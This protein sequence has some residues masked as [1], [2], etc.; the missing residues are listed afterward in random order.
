MPAAENREKSFA[1]VVGKE[2]G[3]ITGAYR[4]SKINFLLLNGVYS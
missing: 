4:I 1:R 3:I 2:E